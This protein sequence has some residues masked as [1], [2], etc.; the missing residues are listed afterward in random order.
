VPQF[1]F[2]ERNGTAF[3]RDDLKGKVS[4]V[5][6]FFTSCRGPC[7]IMNRTYAELYRE[8]EHAPR[9]QLVSITVDP[10]VDSL[11]TLREYALRFNVT[12]DRWVFIR[13]EMDSVVWL[14]ESGFSVSGD[15]PGMHSTKFILVDQQGM[16]RGYYDYDNE[17]SLK[18]L[19]AHIALLARG[20]A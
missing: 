18:Q 10:E 14:A 5:E 8:Y 17:A 6:F 16:I 11:P 3:G 15:L 9:V 20:D 19:R 7:P 4:V 13:D 12:D 2:V 1:D